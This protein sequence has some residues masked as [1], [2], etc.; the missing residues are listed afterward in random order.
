MARTGLS[1]VDVVGGT[2][3]VKLAAVAPDAAA[4]VTV[5]CDTG[6]KY[7]GGDLYAR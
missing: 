7:L 2:P 1:M 5:A 6:L 3:L 4:V